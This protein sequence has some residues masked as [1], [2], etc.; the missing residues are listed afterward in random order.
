MTRG[1]GGLVLP[2]R[3]I[4]AP[5]SRA[6]LAGL[7]ADRPG[8]VVLVRG[9]SVAF[10]ADAAGLL[11]RD[12]RRVEV[13]TVSG[14]PDEAALQAALDALRPAG[15]GQ[16]VAIG[17]GSVLD[18]GKALAAL[19][20]APGPLRDYLEVIGR[21]LPL[22]ADPLP[23]IA[24]PTT[25]GTG[26][27]ATRNAVIAAGEPP[28]KVSLRDARMLPDVAL[29]DAELTAGAPRPV[30]LAAGMDAITQLIEPFL[31]TRAMPATDAL[32]RAAIPPAMR[33]LRVLA[34]TEDA[35]ARDTMLRAAHL[36]GIAL[37]NAGLGAVHGL[38]GVIGGLTGAPHGA[39][40]ARLLP[41]VLRANRA[42]LAGQGGDLARFDE[43]DGMIA[44]AFDASAG[45]PPAKPAPATPAPGAAA[46]LL[47]DF[48]DRHGLPGLAGLGLDAGEIGAVAVDAQAASSMK[49][50]VVPLPT[51]TLRA[52]L[53]ESL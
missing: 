16:V 5:G 20:P 22:A 38:A 12:G 10:A 11:R 42:A 51:G 17:G 46:D 23:F 24:V 15:P 7:L 4:V 48:I 26:A 53:L 37:A 28:R 45:A 32:C 35:A 21:G 36:S 30:T 49:P 41:A 50:N 19:L 44:G 6:R 9:G 29:L 40:C 13:V 31:S 34:R 27:E 14:E 18:F 8:P 52:I 2:G 3:S 1:A 25:A 47:E 33:A 39:I 43:V